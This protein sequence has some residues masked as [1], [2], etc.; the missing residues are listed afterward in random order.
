MRK[1]VHFRI[2]AS[3]LFSSSNFHCCAA[4]QDAC[5]LRSQMKIKIITLHQSWRIEDCFSCENCQMLL[6]PIYVSWL[7]DLSFCLDVIKFA[8]KFQTPFT[9]MIWNLGKQPIFWIGRFFNILSFIIQSFETKAP[10]NW[11]WKEFQKTLFLKSVAHFT[12]MIKLIWI[13]GTRENP[14]F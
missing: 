5:L 10:W 11:F 4:L 7:S 2:R 14:I 9:F 1:H 6:L 12:A 3:L 13:L 8:W